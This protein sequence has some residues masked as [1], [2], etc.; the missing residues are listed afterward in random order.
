[1]LFGG[2]ILHCNYDLGMPLR[3]KEVNSILESSSSRRNIVAAGLCDDKP[4]FPTVRLPFWRNLGEVYPHLDCDAV[5]ER[6]IAF[7]VI[8]HAG[9]IGVEVAIESRFKHIGGDFFGLCRGIG[10]NKKGGE[11]DCKKR[12]VVCHGVPLR[13]ELGGRGTTSNESCPLPRVLFNHPN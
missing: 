11:R 1:M 8:E 3:Q 7:G 12:F 4:V 5:A 13:D 10:D 2:L 6:F 9:V